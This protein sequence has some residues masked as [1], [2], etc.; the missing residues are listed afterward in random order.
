[1]SYDFVWGFGDPVL[2]LYEG[3]GEIVEMVMKEN[4]HSR[5]SGVPTV[6]L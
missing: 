6:G 3:R 2:V 4:P 1:M 5:N